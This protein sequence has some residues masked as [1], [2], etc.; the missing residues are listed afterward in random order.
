[1]NHK[2][3]FQNIW[4]SFKNLFQATW[5]W[6]VFGVCAMRHLWTKFLVA[7]AIGSGYW[8]LA[9]GVELLNPVLPLEQLKRVEGEVVDFY[10]PHKA[11]SNPRIV[12]RT[13]DGHTIKF[14]G[15]WV[16]EDEEKSVKRAR[17][18][19]IAVWYHDYYCL[20]PPFYFKEFMEVRASTGEVYID[21]GNYSYLKNVSY[22]SNIRW[23]KRMLV[24]TVSCLAIVILACFREAIAEKSEQG[25]FIENDSD[26]H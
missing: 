6:R 1:M 17:G 23:C 11:K 4:Q 10:R 13:D 20:W 7:V 15:W 2:H 16:S 21:Y 9:L 18:Q 19:R 8:G 3:A 5:F 26:Q 12:I 22:P 24:L 25:D 14:R